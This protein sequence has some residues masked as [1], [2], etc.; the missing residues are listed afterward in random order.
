MFKRIVYSLIAGLFTIVSASA[1]E[2]PKDFIGAA[3]PSVMESQAT[4]S[5]SSP[6]EVDYRVVISS[7]FG[8]SVIEYIQKYNKMRQDGSK[9][10]IDDLCMSACTLATGLLADANVCVSRYAILAFHSAWVMSFAGPMHSPEG[11]A[12][13]WNIYPEQVKEKLREAGWN[14]TDP[15]PNFIYFKG[16]D[17]YPECA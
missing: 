14:G 6:K 7:D 13:L 10:R 2:Q 1:N 15:H 16:T 12:L 5:P 4:G 17:F 11:T 8:G 9:V 3:P